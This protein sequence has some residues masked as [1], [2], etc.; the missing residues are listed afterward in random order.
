MSNFGPLPLTPGLNALDIIQLGQQGFQQGRALRDKNSLAK[1]AQ[2]AYAAPQD[3]QRGLI[4]QAVGIDPNAGFALSQS[5]GADRTEGFKQ[6]AQGAQLLLA[7]PDDTT[8]QQIHQSLIVPVAQRMGFPVKPQYDASELPV[9]QKFVAMVS[10]G[11]ASAPMNVSPGGEIVDPVTGQVIHAN[12]NFSPQRPTWDS[13]RGGWVMPPSSATPQGQPSANLPNVQ[14][15]I[16]PGTSP[17]VAAAIR[18]AAAADQAQN[19]APGPSQGGFIPVVPPRSAPMSEMDR[20]IAYLRAHKVPEDK[21]TQ[22]VM[23]GNAG[24]PENSLTPDGQA[25]LASAMSHG[26][27]LP[28]PNMGMGAA[29]TAAKMKAVNDL[30]AQFVA[31]GIDP[32]DAVSAMIQ[33]KTATGGL[34]ALQ[35]TAAGVRGWEASAQNQAKIALELSN[36]VSRTGIPVFNKWLLAGRKS[37]EGDVDVQKFANASD[38]FAEEYAKVIGAGNAAA[39]DSAR[40]QAHSMINTAQTGPQYAGVVQLMQREMQQRNA[41]LAAAIQDQRD[42][43]IGKKAAPQGGE[44]TK[45][46]NGQT[47]IKKDGQWYH[48]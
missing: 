29:G 34:Q 35:K 38:T 2:Q 44:E 25:L 27:T 28:I 21:I 19:P 26:Y 42:A 32:N 9:M 37:I 17:E 5:L 18:A 24:A 14:I 12:T 46:I 45:T 48:Q 11:R 36:K 30:A 33:G 31:Q 1:I 10:G 41:G 13:Q 16:A 40:A 8:R 6:L 3:Q 15:D 47:F 4:G 23:G 20:K 7:A 43:V 39:T 22:M